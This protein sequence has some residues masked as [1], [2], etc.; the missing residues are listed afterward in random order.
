MDEEDFA[1]KEFIER[2]LQLFEQDGWKELVEEWDQLYKINNSV[3]NCNSNEQFWKQKG[4]CEALN[5]MINLE[6]L[7]KQMQ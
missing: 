5:L 7:T 6:E 4:F 2:R 1:D 3:M